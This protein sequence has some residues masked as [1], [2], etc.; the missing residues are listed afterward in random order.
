[1]AGTISVEQFTPALINST[2]KPPFRLRR[3]PWPPRMCL[4]CKDIGNLQ[5]GG[6]AWP[7]RCITYC[8]CQALGPT[9]KTG[10]NKNMAKKS[11]KKATKLEATKPLT[12]AFGRR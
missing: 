2:P 12:I 1:V 9:K 4:N 11:L 3:E 5:C 8:V 7:S 6:K 10:G